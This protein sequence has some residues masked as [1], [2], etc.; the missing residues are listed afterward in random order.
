ME[1]LHALL[2]DDHKPCC[3][4]GGGYDV[5]ATRALVAPQAVMLLGAERRTAPFAAACC[6]NELHDVEGPLRALTELMPHPSL[7]SPALFPDAALADAARLAISKLG[8]N[9]RS[10]NY[11]D[12]AMQWRRY[13]KVEFGEAVLNALAARMRAPPLEVAAV[14]AGAGAGADKP[15]AAVVDV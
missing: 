7:A 9:K 11:L 6:S 1:L 10:C 2:N 13:Y 3:G 4:G 14:A 5:E 8:E 12:H 15:A